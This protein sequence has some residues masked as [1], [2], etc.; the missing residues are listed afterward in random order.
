MLKAV[1]IT[2][3]ASTAIVSRTSQEDW[4]KTAEAAFL[5]ADERKE[6]KALQSDEAR[7]QFKEVYW[8][9][10]DPNPITEKNEF[11]ELVLER[12]RRADAQF[13]T[14]KTPGSRSARGLVLV[15]LGPPS[16]QQEIPGPIKNAPE[17]ITPGRISI[18]NDA[19]ST[20]EFQTWSYDRDSRPDLL[21][22]LR[23]SHIEVSF[24][25]EPGQRDELQKPGQF[26][27][28]QET[29]ARASIASALGREAPGVKPD[30]DSPER[31]G[32]AR[33]R[34]LVHLSQHSPN[35]G[36]GPTPVAT[37]IARVLDDE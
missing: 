2:V 9:R 22:L 29:I 21:K 23:V 26:R 13:S 30:G 6:W 4:S 7:N 37:A 25:V 31:E 28:W 20:T 17:M 35:G 15:V 27:E 5:T 18:P 14:K 36:R 11:R 16:T 34:H 33:E 8:K 32:A 10:R 24:I 12:I 1:L 3:L 19:F